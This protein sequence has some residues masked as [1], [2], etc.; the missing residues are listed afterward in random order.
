MTLVQRIRQEQAV[1][2]TDD[3]VVGTVDALH[4]ELLKIKSTDAVS[5]GGDYVLDL[6]FVLDIE[7]D[8]V[9]LTIP[10]AEARERWSPAKM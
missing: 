9:R 8:K 1:I 6:D 3:E 4:G 5:G 10:A 2:G 7:A